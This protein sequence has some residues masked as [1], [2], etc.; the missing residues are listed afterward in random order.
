M[1]TDNDNPYRSPVVP[2]L[3]SHNRTG[4]KPRKRYRLG[5]LLCLLALQ[6]PINCASLLFVAAA[7]ESP[8]LN[9][10]VARC[11]FATTALGFLGVLI[12][13]FVVMI[14]RVTSRAR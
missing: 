9:V 5:T 8:T 11:V 2:N 3:Q 7:V 4:L 10:T 13:I 6:I 1:E 14:A 12:A